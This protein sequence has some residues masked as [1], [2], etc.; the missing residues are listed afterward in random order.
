M[1]RPGD[2]RNR[3][4]RAVAVVA[5]LFRSAASQFARQRPGRQIEPEVASRLIDARG[6]A[7]AAR[8]VAELVD[9][10]NLD[11][12][13]VL[14]MQRRVV[15]LGLDR[16]T[17]FEEDPAGPSYRPA[18]I[19]PIVLAIAQEHHRAITEAIGKRQGTRAEALA[20]EHALLAR[21]VL[22]VALSDRDA[23][24]RVPGGPLINLSL[25]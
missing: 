22:D 7:V 18:F 12:V 21:R 24:R 10:R 15:L 1:V 14:T 16:Q 6:H 4:A 3:R 25:R 17:C 9:A 13:A 2:I 19:P 5:A 23:L 8:G 20:R 11:G